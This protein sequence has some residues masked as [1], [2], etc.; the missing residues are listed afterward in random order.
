MLLVSSRNTIL[1]AGGCLA[2]TIALL[3]DEAPNRLIANADAVADRRIAEAQADPADFAPE[4]SAWDSPASS[5]SA[6]A[7][8]AEGVVA[9]MREVATSPVAALPVAERSALPPSDL[10]GRSPLAG[11]RERSN[12][13]GRNYADDGS[14]DM[15][16]DLRRALG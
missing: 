16:E 15:A 5:A 6:S 3:D 4:R 7:S 8:A 10:V 2:L 9:A 1:F 13:L 14:R 11:V 12:P